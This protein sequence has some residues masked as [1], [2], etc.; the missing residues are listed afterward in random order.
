MFSFIFNKIKNK[1]L[2]NASLLIGVTLLGAFLCI[3]PMFLSGSLNRLLE[4]LFIQQV[5]QSEVFPAAIIEEKVTAFDEFASADEMEERLAGDAKNW[6]NGLGEPMIQEQQI[7]QYRGGSAQTSF[8]SKSKVVHLGYIPKLYEYADVVYG[9]GADGAEQSENT[10]VKEA[11]TRGAYPC[12]ISQTTMDKNDLVVG[13]ELSFKYR[14]YDDDAPEILFVITGIIEEKEEDAFFWYKR[15]G[16]YDQ[17]LFL[18]PEDFSKIAADNEIGEITCMEAALFDYTKINHNNMHNCLSYLRQLREGDAS[19][20]NNFEALLTSYTDQETAIRMILFTFELPIIALLL[21]FL[22]M[23]SGRILEMETTEIAML[24]S[25]GVGRVKIIAIYALQSSIIAFAGCVLGLPVGF[26]LCRLAAGTNAFLSFSLKD[27]SAYGFTWMM[28]P[29]AMIAFVLSVLFM[30]LPVIA[31]SKLTITDRKSL[32]VSVKH[33]PMWEKYYL[34]VLLLLVS[35]YLL[36]NYYKQSDSMAQTIIEG[37]GIDPVIFLD[38]S[39]FILSCGLVVL[40]LAGYLVRLIYRIGK[41]HWTPANFIAFMQII[42][43]AKKQGFISVFLVMTVAMGVFNTNLAR[44]VNEN[45]ED[46]IRYN[47]GCD[48]RLEEQWQLTTIRGQ[49]NTTWSYKEP[50]F[51]KYDALKE[52]GATNLTR[53]LRDD[54][55]DIIIGSK[56]EKGNTLYGIH[57]REFGETAVLK[58]NVNARHW[59]YD[60]NALA[61][62]PK[63]V[64]IS[65]NL[66][67]KYGL[68]EGDKLKYARYSPL[69]NDK[70][71]ATVEA[72]VVGIVN[73]FPGYESTVYRMTEDG[74]VEAKEQY[75]LVANYANVISDFSQTPYSVW[76]RL[77]DNADADKIKTVLKEIAPNLKEHTFLDEEIQKNRDSAMLQI[78]NGMFSVGFIISLLICVVGFLIYWVLTIRERELLYGIYRAMGMSM[79]E[80]VKMLITEQLFSSLLAAVSGFGVGALTTF[81]FTKLISIVYLPRKHNLPLTIFVRAS[82]SVRII[83]TIAVS[84]LVCFFIMR[85]LIRDL[86]ITKALK[87]G[88]D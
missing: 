31:L 70:T 87:M 15:L 24:K 69:N 17:M 18:L 3:Y 72:R 83:A 59:F 32:R 63:G 46:R 78:T 29:F 14:T 56:T 67:A 48:L 79:R 39:L 81:L 9:I 51:L 66:A 57:T 7:M 12:V 21:L 33:K 27:V 41:K 4:T 47:L 6:E 16:E 2:L 80:I 44:T 10:F 40:R 5:E 61:E 84:F 88:E 60:L 50:D 23:V 68:K 55:T 30:T 1:K 11:L 35:G 38:S 86:N 65:A 76:V 73:A 74:S 85:R 71:Y 53:V 43:G 62:D 82:D 54:N 22:Y 42:R 13:E 20:S 19:V 25:R 58:D 45:A 26:L 75:L 37:G 64:I 8:G 36:Y 28:I 52:Y 34:D 77:N 49:T